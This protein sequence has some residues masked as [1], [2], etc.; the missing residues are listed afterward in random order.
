MEY[1]NVDLSDEQTGLSSMKLPEVCMPVYKE[2]VKEMTEVIKDAQMRDIFYSLS[3]GG[4]C[5]LFP[6]RQVLPP[7]IWHI[8]IKKQANGSVWSGN[9]ILCGN[10]N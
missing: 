4:T 2:I 6:K 7:E 1:S 8:C 10:R 3:T 5:R 9:L